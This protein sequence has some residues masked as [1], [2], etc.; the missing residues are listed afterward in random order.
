MFNLT[1]DN[2]ADFDF[3][4]SDGTPVTFTKITS[5]N[6]IQVRIPDDHADADGDP[7]KIFRRDGSHYKDELDVTLS[8]TPKASEASTI[9]EVDFTP[10]TDDMSGKLVVI[11][12]VVY[13]L[14]KVGDLLLEAA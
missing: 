2:A 13:S 4:L 6:N 3:A 11:D 5:K 7:L 9:T 10:A 1:Q 12:D 8:A 14:T